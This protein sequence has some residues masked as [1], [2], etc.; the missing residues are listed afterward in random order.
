[1]KITSIDIKHYRIP[2]DPPFRASWDPKP[3]TQFGSTVVSVHTDEGITGVASGDLM[4]GFAGHENLFIGQDPF[5]IERHSQIIDNID[6]HYGRNWPLDLALWDLMGKATGQPIY[7]LLGGRQDKMR[8]YASTGEMLAPEVR[9]ERAIGLVEEGFKAMK[10]RFHN[11]N[12]RDDIKIVEAVRKAVGN[13]LEIMVDAN[14]GW[15]M[16]WDVERTWDLKQAYQVAKELEHL[17]VLWLE[18]PLPCHDFTGMAQLRQMVGIR[19]AGGEMNR[20]WYDFREMI[21]HG[22]LDV[23]QPDVALTGGFTQIKKVAEMAQAN[24]HWFTPHSWSNGVGMLAN[25]QLTCA[26]STCPYFEVPYDP[27][28]WTP[29]RRDFIQADKMKVDK[30]GC[31]Y[32]PDKPGLGFELDTEMLA[33]YEINQVHMW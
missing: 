12:P 30:D 19:I 21:R 31:I 20:N 26:I 3:R 28:T 32:A 23:Y 1:M 16:P 22:S 24:G 29:E 18:E 7:K 11:A 9:A 13:K 5:Q 2:L 10:I 15:K 33:K 8:A 25:L 6:L 17:G 27:P 14:Q 4:V